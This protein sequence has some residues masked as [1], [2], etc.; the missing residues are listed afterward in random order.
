MVD[1]LEFI[2]VFVGYILK[3]LAGQVT[4]EHVQFVKNNLIVACKYFELC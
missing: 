4:Q 2:F 3:I 1:L